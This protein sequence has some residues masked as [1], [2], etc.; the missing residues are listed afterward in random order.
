MGA[1]C[2]LVLAPESG[3]GWGSGR[4][5]T[6]RAGEEAED[7]EGEEAESHLDTEDHKDTNSAMLTSHQTAKRK[8][9]RTCADWWKCARK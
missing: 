3:S 7:R 9:Q 2:G 6:D 1:L 5:A 4:G 8:K